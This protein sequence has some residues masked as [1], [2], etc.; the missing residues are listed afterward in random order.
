MSN[1]TPLV[2]EPFFGGFVLETLTVGMYGESRNAIREYIQNGFDSIQK[3]RALGYLGENEG[4]IE[5]KMSEDKDSLIIRD[6]GTGISVDQAAQQLTRVGASTKDPNFSAGFRGI[7]RLAGIGFSNTVTF[8]TK[9]RGERAVTT[10]CFHGDSMRDLMSPSKGSGITAEAL[11]RQC[12]DGSVSESG[13]INDHYFEVKLEGFVDAPEECASFELMEEFVSQVA[14]VG[15]HPSFPFK[16]VL[17]AAAAKCGLPIEEVKVTL[18]D[19]ARPAAPVTKGYKETYRLN[20]GDIKLS[21]CESYFSPDLKWWAWVGKK[22]ESG[23]YV[24]SR[25]SGIRVRMKNIQIDGTDVIREIFKK[26]AKSFDRF[27]DWTVGEV[28][29]RPSVLVPNARRDGFEETPAWKVIRKELLTEIVNV[30]GAES[31]TIS[32]A[33]QTS[34]PALT[35]QVKEASTELERLRRS[36]FKN[37]DKVRELS[38]EVTKLADL[39]ALSSEIMDIKSEADGK[40]GKAQEQIDLETVQQEARDELLKQLLQLFERKLSPT[41]FIEVRSVMRKE[42]GDFEA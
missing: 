6:N 10:V 40:I 15:Y 1:P 31:Y 39:Q 18:K 37:L 12:V 41:C 29:V 23:S 34:L 17:N 35:E 21:Q 5:I 38:V 14:P 26:R 16:A 3:A 32:N 7:G 27:Q 22:T 19:G 24:D 30:I 25:V 11:L 8:V 33:G 28:F 36:N 20:T 9:T 4:L 2:I 42:Y 13:E